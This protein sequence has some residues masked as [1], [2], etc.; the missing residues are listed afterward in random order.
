[1]PDAQP[2]TVHL[3]SF[4][5]RYSGLPKEFHDE[6]DDGMGGGFVFD[7]RPLPNPFWEE[8]LRHHTGQDAVIRDYMGNQPQ[9]ADFVGHV[10]ALLLP[11][12]R[13]RRKQGRPLLRAA[14]GCTGGRHRSVY[15][16]ECLR[17]ALEQA[18]FRVELRHIDIRS[19]PDDP[20]RTQP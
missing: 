17:D 13:N 12:A 14:F 19:R 16:A 5:Y 15:V 20:D 3:V 2:L 10:S 7:C 1:M 6:A 8:S 4:G 9:V 11:A 18:G